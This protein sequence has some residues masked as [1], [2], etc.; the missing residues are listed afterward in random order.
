MIK[1][2]TSKGRDYMLNIWQII[3]SFVGVG[4]AVY[5]LNVNSVDL[6]SYVYLFL[7]ASFLTLAVS[8]LKEKKKRIGMLT[9]FV[10]L[11]MFYVSFQGIFFT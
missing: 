7:G 5:D 10:T 6:S 2:E 1:E 8:Q 11:L 3:F 4:I 9:I